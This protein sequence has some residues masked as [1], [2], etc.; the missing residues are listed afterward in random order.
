MRDDIS[1][2]NVINIKPGETKVIGMPPGA[3]DGAE[4]VRFQIGQGFVVQH[5]HAHTT[6]AGTY[7]TITL[8]KNKQGE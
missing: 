7:L 1:A 2:D 6:D 8:W 4:Y 5:K 3:D